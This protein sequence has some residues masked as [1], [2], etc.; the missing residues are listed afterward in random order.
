[1]VN[2]QRPPPMHV[3]FAASISTR[4]ISLVS[5]P[6]ASWPHVAARNTLPEKRILVLREI[7]ARER[8]LAVLGLVLNILLCE[9]CERL[10]L[11]ALQRMPRSLVVDSTS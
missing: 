1:M 10:V 3:A 9:N 11:P 6:P 5:I 2:L 8:A 7:L 4:V